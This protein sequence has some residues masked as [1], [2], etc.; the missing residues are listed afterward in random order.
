MDAEA[1][2]IALQT[3]A[4]TFSQVVS[5]EEGDWIVKGFIDTLIASWRW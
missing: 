1:F 4:A 3:R 5:T 2:L